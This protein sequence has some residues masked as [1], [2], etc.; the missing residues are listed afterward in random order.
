MW[1]CFH[2]ISSNKVIIWPW[3]LITPA[4]KYPKISI[5]YKKMCCYFKVDQGDRCSIWILCIK[6]RNLH[7]HCKRKAW[8][9]HNTRGR[10]QDG[11]VDVWVA[12]AWFCCC[13]CEPKL[14]RDR[15]KTLITIISGLYLSHTPRLISRMCFIQSDTHDSG[16]R[17]EL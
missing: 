10:S 4:V 8:K 13:C 17:K 2:C 12:S 15:V 16:T 7:V 14:V 3:S 9:R 5:N 1:C 6:W 11:C